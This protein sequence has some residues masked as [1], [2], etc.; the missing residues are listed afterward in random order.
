MPKMKA[1][2]VTEPHSVFQVI[3]GDVPSPAAGHVRIQVVA[4]GICLY[5]TQGPRQK[6]SLLPRLANRLRPISCA[7]YTEWCRT[8][9]N[10][11]V[12]LIAGST[13]A[14]LFP[15]ILRGCDNIPQ[16]NTRWSLACKVLGE[17]QL[18]GGCDLP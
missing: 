14:R 6:T 1:A 12:G 9:W 11:G 18:N 16:G 17:F 3:E 10:H 13:K 5:C 4:C 2:P 15:L 8:S 7:C